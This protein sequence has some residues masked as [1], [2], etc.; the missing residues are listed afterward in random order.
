MQSVLEWVLIPFSCI[1]DQ[2]MMLYDGNMACWFLLIFMCNGGKNLSALTFITKKKKN[3]QK[4]L[5]EYIFPVFRRQM[6]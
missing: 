2:A 1:L 6:G 4:N 5:L 3:I